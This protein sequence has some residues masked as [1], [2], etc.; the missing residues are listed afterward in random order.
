LR[1]VAAFVDTLPEK[2]RVALVLRKRQ[3]L[4]YVEIAAAL[5]SSETAARVNVH[6]ALRKLRDRFADRL[7]DGDQ[8]LAEPPFTGGLRPA[9]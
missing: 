4:G 1:E 2:Q 5:H 7:D 9:S 8:R 6:E 3:G